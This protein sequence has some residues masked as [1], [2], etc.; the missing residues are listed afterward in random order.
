MQPIGRRAIIPAGKTLLDAAQSAGVELMSICGGVGACNSCKVHLMSGEVSPPTEVEEAEFTRE[1]LARGLRLACQAYPLSDVKIDIPPESLTTPQRLQV[2]GQVEDVQPTPA[3]V[4]VDVDIDPPSLT[5]LRS[6]SERL[7]TVLAHAIDRPSLHIEYPVL[8]TLSERMRSLSWSARAALRGDSLI[9]LLP[10]ASEAQGATRLVG[11]AVDIGT[12]KLAAFL[13]DLQ[14]GE[15]LFKTGAMNPQIAFGE[16]VIAR[17]AYANKFPDDPITHQPGEGRRILQSRLI[18]T[19]NGMIDEML[20]ESRRQGTPIQREQIVD[21]VI[22]GNTAMHHLFA[23][24]PVHQLG[25]SPYVPAVGEAVQIAARDLGL[26]LAP[27]ANVYL[28]PNVAGYVGA[29]HVAMLLATIFSQF[30]SAVQDGQVVLAL[31]IGTN[32]EISLAAG[33]E[34]VS[35]SCASGPAFEGAHIRDGMRAAPGAIERMQILDGKVHIKTIGDQPPVGICGSGILDS[36]AQMIR[37]GALDGRGAIVQTHPQVR[38]EGRQAEFVLAPGAITGH[39]HDLVVTR[40]DVNEI[41][42]AKAAIRA[43]IKLLLDETGAQPE[44][45]DQF[46]VAGAFGTYIDLESAIRVGMFPQLP[47]ERFH[48]VGNAAGA[49][50]R[51]MLISTSRRKLAEEVVNRIKY[52]ELSNHPNFT[53]E[54]SKA[55]FFPS[56]K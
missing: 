33:G 11:M 20:D 31:D 30:Y 8:T 43:G 54:F 47:L 29:D 37:A 15:T 16:D 39:G 10:R 44:Q 56:M 35:C 53:N 25:A 12:T 6:D 4:A 41:Q 9:A 1:E 2:E 26:G 27:G 13:V 45:I 14:S 24:L 55:L 42:L 49:G 7:L 48:Q 23:S 36:I 51:Q 18:D 38:A 34:L 3:V 5:D 50:A 19:L 21:A 32:T 28:P 40:K 17:I 52:I 46:V 22:V